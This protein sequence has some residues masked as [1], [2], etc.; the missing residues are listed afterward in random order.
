MSQKLN[1]EITIKSIIKFAFPSVLMMVVMSLYTVVD[2]AFVSR[3]IGT[4]AFSSV[5]IIYP[6]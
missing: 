3:L 2:G 5:N 4:S 6:D 1:Q